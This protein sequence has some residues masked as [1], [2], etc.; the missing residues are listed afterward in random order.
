MTKTKEEGGASRN[1]LRKVS[2]DTRFNLEIAHSLLSEDFANIFF[3]R[4]I[5]MNSKVNRSMVEVVV[6]ENGTTWMT[7]AWVKIKL[8]A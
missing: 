7:V 2:R 8:S 3:Y 4:R 5:T 6:K 1:I